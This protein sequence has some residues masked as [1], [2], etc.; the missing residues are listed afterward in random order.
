MALHK[1]WLLPFAMVIGKQ[2][3]NGP[4][5][6]LGDQQ[7]LFTERFALK[8]LGKASLI[9]NP[10]ADITP[11]H[12]HPECISFRSLLSLL[13]VGEYSDIDMNGSAALNIDL[14]KPLPLEYC[15]IAGGVFDLGTLEHVFD[16]GEGF[17]NVVRLLRPG[18]VVIHFSPITAFNHGLWNLS[19]QVFFGFY[20]ANNFEILEHAVIFS[21]FYTLW[22]S[23]VGPVIPEEMDR[24]SERNRTI[25]RV[26]SRSK[27]LQYFCNFCFHPPR[28]FQFFAA[29]KVLSGDDAKPFY[30]V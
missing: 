29:R 22:S 14:G 1:D 21:P 2:R 12:V 27:F 10:R 24:K 28:M 4:C 9:A 7:T 18:G 30:Q 25:F 16:I 15:G 13:G 11:D 20:E 5:F 23:L 26:N 3:V 17:R 8:Q 6:G 19:P